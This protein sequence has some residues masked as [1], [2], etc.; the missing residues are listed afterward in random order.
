MRILLAQFYS[1]Q[2]TPDYGIIA[3]ELRARDHQAW[4]ATPDAKGDLCVRAGEQLV[5]TVPGVQKPVGRFAGLPIISSLLW[6]KAAFAYEQRVR[7][8][9]RQ[10]EPNIVQINPADLGLFEILP[11]FMPDWMQFILDFRQID[12]RDYGRSVF[13]RLKNA[14]YRFKRE[15]VARYV[16][17]RAAFLHAAGARKVLGVNWRK[18]GVVVPLGVACRFLEQPH[19]FEQPDKLEAKT[20]FIYLGTISTQRKLDLL[21]L[22]AKKML[23]QTNQFEITFIGPD[24]TN[25]F[26]QTMIADLDLGQNI[27]I[28]APVAYED[29]PAVLVTYNVALAIVPERPFDWQ[30]HPT[31]KALEYRALG[32]PM[33]AT[34]FEPNRHI[35]ENGRN[36]LLVNNTV[37][38]IADAMLCYVQDHDFRTKSGQDAA[39]MRQGRPWHDVVDRYV[40]LYT[41][42][43]PKPDALE[44][45]K[46]I[47]Q[48]TS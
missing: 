34:D 45:E 33:I 4:V 1:H 8:M 9:L 20:T 31:L 14:F 47:R 6:K 39:A 28:K 25:G 42:L 19:P 21:L 11:L 46:Q 29:V 38:D 48:T 13:G 5:A 3:A 30:Y 43:L 36:G 16:Y 26:Y 2:P 7:K 18:W 32:I 24:A 27:T 22:A 37:D 41:S 10:L 23:H 35:V 44:A 17:T 40:T 15:T 12:E